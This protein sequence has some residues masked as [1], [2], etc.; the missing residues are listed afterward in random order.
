MSAKRSGFCLISKETAFVFRLR[1]MFPRISTKARARFVTLELSCLST[2]TM[3][4][5]GKRFGM[6]AVSP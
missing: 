4:P 2:L 6:S 3:L 1:R 5:A